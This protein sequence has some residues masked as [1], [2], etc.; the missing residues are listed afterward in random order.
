MLATRADNEVLA[1][2][3]GQSENG[4]ALGTFA[5]DMSFSVFEFVFTQG[6]E[7]TELFVFPAPFSDVSGEHA[8]EDEKG[9]GE[10]DKRYYQIKNNG[11]NE[12]G[13]DRMNKN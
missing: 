13:Q 12:D 4:F 2:C 7:S 5:I 6:K 10:G 3:F 8:V 11:F 1:F 9:K